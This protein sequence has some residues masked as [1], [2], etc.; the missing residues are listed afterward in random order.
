MTTAS[1]MT[2]EHLGQDATAAAAKW[3]EGVPRTDEEAH[4]ARPRAHGA[5]A[6][7]RNEMEHTIEIAENPEGYSE[8]TF[9]YVIWIGPKSDG[10]CS[11]DGGYSSREAA[12]KAAKAHAARLA[13][14]E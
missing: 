11:F 3:L 10:T 14:D 12:R 2:T 5:R 9:G 6:P 4:E 7:R 8:G 13:K 1:K